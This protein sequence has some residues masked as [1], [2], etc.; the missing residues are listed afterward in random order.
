MKD[1]SSILREAVLG[2]LPKNNLRKVRKLGTSMSRHQI[3]CG[4]QIP[5][6]CVSAASRGRARQY[7]SRRVEI[8]SC[9]Y[10][11]H[12]TIRSEITHDL[13]IGSPA[14]GNCASRSRYLSCQMALSR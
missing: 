14:R 3:A 11:R 8:G 12:R 9:E 6:Q 13:L 5:M 10:S 7:F 2:M 1:P 4:I